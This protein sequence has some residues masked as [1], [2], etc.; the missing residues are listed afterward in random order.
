M[1]ASFL[2]LFL[3]L[4]LVLLL[5]TYL[6]GA[7]LVI[8]WIILGFSYV[9]SMTYMD[10]LL[11]LLMGSREVKRLDTPELHEVALQQAYKLGL[12]E[13]RIY[14]YN[15]QMERAFV[16]QHLNR[17]SLVIEKRLI[18]SCNSLEL[19]AICFFLLLQAKI[20]L[21]VQRTKAMFL[22]GIISSAFYKLAE[23]LGKFVSFPD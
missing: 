19:T 23:I 8:A 20:G 21:S 15:G 18:D 17:I 5:H 9:I 22:V 1:K 14:I 4:F 12:P 16:F 6:T 11:L 10:A 3:V 7:S 13:P 2:N